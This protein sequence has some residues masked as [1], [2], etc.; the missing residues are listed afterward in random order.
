LSPCN[1]F[2]LDPRHC[3]AFPQ[4][5]QPFS[6]ATRIDA[7]QVQ[8]A[9]PSVAPQAPRQYHFDLSKNRGRNMQ[10]LFWSLLGILAGA[11]IAI[12]APINADL[13][14][15]LGSAIA[16]AAASFLAGAVALAGLTAV[17][18]IAGGVWPQ[19]AAPRP[20]LYVA[21]GLLGS[22]YVTTVIL[23]A[24][25]I[26]VAAVMGLAIAGQLMAGVLLDRVG[27]MGLPV[28]EITAGR[29]VGALLLVAGA[30]TI[31]LT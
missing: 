9:E 26:G 21:G 28:H 27:F 16:A 31:R 15:G 4:R 23:L 8:P 24:P 29:A 13:A 6:G 12:Q 25:R 14:R 1:A 7:L 3:K 11:C 10:A 20:W 5:R 17:G 2:F 18:G 19:F 30:L 22:I